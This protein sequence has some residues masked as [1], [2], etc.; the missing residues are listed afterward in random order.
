MIWPRRHR[1]SV[2]EQPLLDAAQQLALRQLAEDAR[3]PLWERRF[4]RQGQQ[5][6]RPSPLRGSGMDYDESRPFMPGDDRRHLN[7]RLY[8]RTGEPH[9]KLFSEERRPQLML[10]LDRR[11]AM[12]MGSRTRLKLTQGVRLAVVLA[13]MAQSRGMAVSALCLQSATRFYRRRQGVSATLELARALA[14]PAPPV[15]G[16]EEPGLTTGLAQL[17]AHLVPGSQV[18]LI[19]DFADLGEAD[20]ALL[21]QLAAEHDLS[22]FHLHDP[23]EAGLPDGRLRVAIGEGRALELDGRDAQLRQ[24]YSRRMRERDRAIESRLRQSG[25]QYT[26]LGTEQSLDELIT[27]GTSHGH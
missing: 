19:S 1:P 10:L 9:L 22:A 13:W 14:A 11:R 5:G 21:W 18:C 16:A 25:G 24:E 2:L 17:R 8:A 26:R 4:P 15:S 6:E 23:M 3:S 12:R 27:G 7:W 20:E